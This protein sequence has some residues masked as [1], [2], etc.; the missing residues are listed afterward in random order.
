[1]ITVFLTLVHIIV[2]LMLILVILLQA[3]RG[4]GLAGPSFASGNV[5]SLFGTRAGDFLTKATSVSA[6]CFLLTCIG[7]NLTEAHK[8]RS[9]LDV[10]RNQTAPVDIEAIKKALEQ[11][12]K[13]GEANSGTPKAVATQRTEPAATDA[14]PAAKTAA[15]S[16]PPAAE[17]AAST[18]PV[19]SANSSQPPPVSS[20]S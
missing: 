11:V 8:S 13:E 1:M 5:Q 4:Q 10:K 19:P 9:L 18:P 17:P 12:K 6:I 14:I 15:A 2:C 3:G 7:L 16:T 20:K